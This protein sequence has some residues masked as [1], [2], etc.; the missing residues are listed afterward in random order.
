MKPLNFQS[1][2]IAGLFILI[3]CVAFI[4]S[5]IQNWIVSIIFVTIII[6]CLIKVFKSEDASLAA[7]WIGAI[8]LGCYFIWSIGCLAYL[9]EI[10]FLNHLL[11]KNYAII[12]YGVIGSVILTLPLYY[13]SQVETVND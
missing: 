7:V 5:F 10:N 1:R 13:F 12:C 3:S 11:S 8:A 6:S 4:A 9:C 2:I